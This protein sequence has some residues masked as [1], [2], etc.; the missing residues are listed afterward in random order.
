MQTS[1]CG[2]CGE[3]KTPDFYHQPYCSNCMSVQSE[4]AEKAVA[5][6]TDPYTAAR[7][8]LVGRS[9]STHQ[10]RFDPRIPVDRHQI[11]L[12]DPANTG[13]G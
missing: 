1:T 12:P 13:R 8:A 2:N 5:N 9:F 4:A 11:V 3:A 10:G 6:D 7:E